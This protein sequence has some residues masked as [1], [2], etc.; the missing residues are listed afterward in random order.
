MYKN[1]SAAGVIEEEN[2]DLTLEDVSTSCPKV[3]IITNTHPMDVHP[4]SPNAALEEE[5]DTAHTIT[6]DNDDTSV[7]AAV[8]SSSWR[9]NVIILGHVFVHAVLISSVVGPIVVSINKVYLYD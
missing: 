5:R 2:S 6:E 3:D 9:L 4:L 7:A 8:M 1:R